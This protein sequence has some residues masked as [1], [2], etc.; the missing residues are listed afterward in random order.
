[1]DKGGV[2]EDGR[3]QSLEKGGDCEG[4]GL[5]NVKRRRRA[6]TSVVRGIR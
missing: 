4:A 3:G 2:C 5:W 6:L 1:M